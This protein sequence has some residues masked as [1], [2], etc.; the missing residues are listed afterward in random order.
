MPTCKLP[1]KSSFDN[2]RV[3]LQ[4]FEVIDDSFKILNDREFDSLIN[5]LEQNNIKAYNI[6]G[7]PWLKDVSRGS[8]YAI[9][10]LKVLDKI[11]Q[12]RKDLGLYED[13]LSAEILEGKITRVLSNED[14]EKVNKIFKKYPKLDSLFSGNKEVYNLYL[15]SI[16]PQSSDEFKAKLFFHGTKNPIEGGK[17]KVSDKSLG[18]ALWFT[19]QVGYAKRIQNYAEEED[20]PLV[21]GVILN[22]Q[23]PKHFFNSSGSIL[24]QRP[25]DF[26]K[27]YDR[28]KNDGAVFHHPESS[29]G[30]F[31]NEGGYNQI[32]VFDGNQVHIIGDE[33]D[34]NKAKEFLKSAQISN[35]EVIP[36][37]EQVQLDSNQTLKWIDSELQFEKKLNQRLFSILKEFN[38]EIAIDEYEV[39]LKEYKNVRGLA[40]VVN[41]VILLSPGKKGESVFPEEAS[42]LLVALL[43]IN[44]PLVSAIIDKMKHGQWKNNNEDKF[45]RIK[46]AVKNNPLYKKEDGS[47]NWKK[48]Y[49][50]AVGQFVSEYLKKNE[51]IEPSLL[52]LAIKLVQDVVD[53]IGFYLDKYGLMPYNPYNLKSLPDLGN[54]IASDILLGGREVIKK[55]IPDGYEMVSYNESLEKQPLIKNINNIIISNK[56]IFLTGSLALRAQGKIFRS[57]D[58]LIHDLDY[59]TNLSSDKIEEFLKSNFKNFEKAHSTWYNAKNNSYTETYYVPL[60]PSDTIILPDKERIIVTDGEIEQESWVYRPDKVTTKLKGGVIAIDFFIE[61]RETAKWKE[62]SRYDRAFEAKLWYSRPKDI[63]DYQY[64]DPSKELRQQGLFK[65]N[66]VFTKQEL[67]N[68]N[69]SISDPSLKERL[70]K[71]KSEIYVNELLDNIISSST[72]TKFTKTVAKQLKKLKLSENSTIYLIDGVNENTAAF[73]Y[74]PT[75]DIYVYT[76]SNFKG[77]LADNSILHEIIH[78]YTFQKLKH[79]PEGRQKL[80]QLFVK[81]K[82]VILNKYP[83]SDFYG[84]TNA[85]EFLTEGLTNPDFIAVLSE[86]PID[87]KETILEAF[88]YFVLDILG[89]GNKGVNSIFSELYQT[90]LD[91]SDIGKQDIGSL[92]DSGLRL[93]QGELGDNFF[94][95][96]DEKPYHVTPELKSTL[97]Q[98]VRKLNPD[99]KIEVLD[100]LLERRGVNGIAKISEFVIQL[101]KGREGS[102][103]EETA[104]FLIELLDND[105]PLK[106]TMKDE[107]TRTRL[108]KNLRQHPGYKKVFG[109]DLD[110]FKREAM[111]KL[112][113]IYLTDKESFKYQVGSDSVYENI[114]RW[115]KDFFRWIKGKSNSI[116]SFIEAADK[117][118]NLDTT[119]LVLDQARAIDEMYSAGDFF[120]EPTTLTTVR[121]LNTTKYDRVLV[122]L[123]DTVFDTKGYSWDNPLEKRSVLMGN[124]PEKLKKFY[125][126]VDLTNLGR[127]LQDKITAGS[128]SNVTF[129]SSMLPHEILIQRLKD[130]F[131][132]GVQVSFVNQPGVLEDEQGNPIKEI[133]NNP[134][135]DFFK[136]FGVMET[137]IVDNKP[138][139]VDFN[140]NFRQYTNSNATI[141]E[142]LLDKIQRQTREEDQKRRRDSFLEELKRV[143]RNSVT[144]KIGE[145][146]QIIRNEYKSIEALEQRL[147]KEDLGEDYDSLFRE[148]GDLL[149]PITQADKG[150]RLLEK[151]NKFEEASIQF[152][153]TIEAVTNFFKDRN[154]ANYEQIRQRLAKATEDEIDMAIQELSL[155]NKMGQK[156]E[157]FITDFTVLLKDVPNANTTKDLLGA[158]GEE[159]RLSK[160]KSRELAVQAIGEKF[161]PLLEGYNANRLADVNIM[162]ERLEKAS[163][164]D[165]P[166]IEKTIKELTKDQKESGKFVDAGDIIDVLNGEEK[167]LNSVTVYIKTLPNTSDNVVG[168][169]AKLLRKAQAEVEVSEIA[170]AQQLGYEIS[171]LEKSAGIT[172]KEWQ[173]KLLY[174]DNVLVWEGEGENRRQVPKPAWTLLHG[175]KDEWKKD[176]EYNKVQEKRK[177][178]KTAEQSNATNVQELFD[179]YVEERDKYQNWLNANWYQEYKQEFYERYKELQTPE[180]KSLFEEIKEF[181]EDIYSEIAI[182]EA[183]SQYQEGASLRDTTRKIH[184]KHNE[185]KEKKRDVNFDGT[186]KVGR[187]LEIAKLLQQ[188]A[189]I[190]QEF[191]E[192]KHD[193]P[194]FRRD[195]LTFLKTQN[196]DT[197]LFENIKLKLNED[198]L[199]DLFKYVRKNNLFKT[200]DWLENNTKTQFHKDWYEKR[201]ELSDK[202]SDLSDQIADALQNPHKSTLS[203]LWQELFTL[204]SNLRDEDHVFDGAMASIEIQAKVKEFESEIERIKQLSKELPGS[205]SPQI[206]ALKKELREYVKTLSELQQKRVTDSYKD[207]FNEMMSQTGFKE[208]YNEN[209]NNIYMEG[210][211]LI[212]FINYS[213]LHKK[214]AENPE[215]DF[216]KWFNANQ[217]EKEYFDGEGVSKGWFPTYIWMQIEPTDA[218]FVLTVPSFKYSNRVVQ[219]KHKTLKEEKTFNFQLNEWNPKSVEFMNP[220]YKQ[221]MEST[222]SK[223]RAMFAILGKLN[224]HH[225]STQGDTN[226]REGK[227][228]YTLPYV[229]KQIYEDGY[230][231][232]MKRD[233]FDQTNRFEE[234]E[235]NFQETGRKTGVKKT[236]DKLK[237]WWNNQEQAEEETEEI[238]KIMRIAVPFT[239]YHAPENISKDALLSIVRFSASTRQ[240]DKMMKSLPLLNLIEDSLQSTSKVDKRGKPV[241]NQKERVKAL[242]FLKENLIYGINNQFELGTDIVGRGI[243]STL[244]TVRKVNTIGSLGLNVAN[245]VKNNFQ[246][247]LQNLIGST[248]ADWSSSKSMTKASLNIKTNYAW[249]LSQGEKSLPQRDIHFHI[250]AYYNPELEGNIYDNVLKGSTKR[251]AATANIMLFNKAMEFS[252]S[253]NLLFG[254]LYHKKVKNQEGEIKELF[255]ILTVVNGRL[256]PKEGFVDLQTGQKINDDYLLNDKLAYSTVSEY[257]QGK[258]SAKTYLSTLTIGQALEYFKRWLLPMLRRRF[259]SKKANYMVGDDLEGYWRVWARLSL[260]MLRDILTTHRANWNSYTPREQREY[261]VALKE[262]GVMFSTLMILSL[263][264]GFDADDPDKFKKLKNNSMM[265]NYALLLLIQTKNETEALSAMPFINTET[266]FIPPLLTEGTKFLTNPTIGLA[267]IDNTWKTLNYSYELLIGSE[268]AYYD[269]NMPQFGIEKGDSKAWRYMSKV[270][271]YDEILNAD[272]P[273]QKI[274]T[275]I[276]NMKR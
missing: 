198:N 98:F 113:A 127:E 122:N 77:G 142:R 24:V 167:D 252:I 204:T 119:S 8:E 203:D 186:P 183:E 217:I 246:G 216:T 169:T 106:K 259:D 19:K 124:N 1:Y 145:G 65:N 194:R 126:N 62:F 195:F 52:E 219:E 125:E 275:V 66:L 165:K 79:N 139:K 153:G 218:K 222:N 53:K 258:V 129:Y 94:Q 197:E 35:Q 55:D 150:K 148:D 267:I 163:E 273:D 120:T 172:E 177:L 199:T 101:Q 42:H 263:I 253:S 210:I 155:V 243:D 76:K 137:I 260:N 117:I 81:A 272:D 185:L 103:T 270:I 51:N 211:N 214:L 54:Y 202:I 206:K 2:S 196:L 74:P 227:T 86:I 75:N 250:L 33:N 83:N 41:K 118:V 262:I 205:D 39:L 261:I 36:P 115:I 237:A 220:A 96:A 56:D 269:K 212:D 189:L 223:D 179:E 105:S 57:S 200:L 32:V 87:K 152:F 85:D 78:S 100:D 159:I 121:N 21:Y 99:F 166:A 61:S 249:F 22:I 131:G 130:L 176:V 48:V 80:E 144:A 208:I 88:V 30:K 111:A 63:V 9:P 20:N 14:I 158:L 13:Q 161:E 112:V 12:K 232:T 209:E 187:D 234:G 135:G 178:W 257:V 268:T 37:D 151:M 181:Q 141:Y 18:K 114:L 28:S 173:D 143:D 201:K 102:L 138:P 164:G 11:D 238:Q 255:D 123:S 73:L 157:N 251:N 128:I 226:V 60:N 97:E 174:Q 245:V 171:E 44:H 154:D 50:E 70:F 84:L 58:E 59:V 95:L 29:D 134:I 45:K 149:L 67:N 241:D 193:F 132:D 4:D 82:Q 274:R 3:F 108:Y 64:F 109:N 229:K 175:F 68:P 247:R 27:Q 49:L 15:E 104:H 271:Q 23:N 71:G 276:G 7:K 254:H 89:I 47:T 180:N 221:L 162:R 5:E 248:F 38:V 170:R 240:A 190:D 168:L 26:E 6:S 184:S 147:S 225:L 244:R 224:S 107:I 34:I 265:E 17:F 231:Q 133:V 43:G 40:D 156:W 192:Y 236:L 264:F 116:A 242:K 93:R 207:T 69:V 235:G 110:G 230:L 266:S 256:T 10:N 16:F 160:I 191:F 146:F 91:I 182:L 136:S 90:F 25:A 213:G 140:I 31:T 233:F 188:K 228:R 239:K 92:I 46:N 72:A 215:H